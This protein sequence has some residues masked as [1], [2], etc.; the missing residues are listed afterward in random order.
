MRGRLW[1]ATD[2]GLAEEVRL[3]LVQDLMAARRAVRA[4]RGDAE[5][6]R[7][8]RA[9]GDAA[10][11]ALGERGTVWWD[12]GAPDYDR[13]MAKNTPY[14]DWWKTRREDAEG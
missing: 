4:A 10:K 5:A 1:R 7:A 9:R 6:T 14:A 13:R 2:P 11:V 12:D 3:R 8:A